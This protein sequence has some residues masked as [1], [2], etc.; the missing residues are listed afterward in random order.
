M[1]LLVARR[2]R[3]DVVPG[4]APAPAAGVGGGASS[5]GG[6]LGRRRHARERRA[7]RHDDVGAE[8]EVARARR[9]ASVEALVS[10]SERRNRSA[11][12]AARARACSRRRSR[13]GSPSAACRPRRCAASRPSGAR[14]SRSS[15]DALHARAVD[16]HDAAAWPAGSPSARSSSSPVFLAPPDE[17]AAEAARDRLR[18]RGIGILELGHGRR[19]SPRARPSRP[20]RRR[21]SACRR[22]A[23]PAPSCRA[24]SRRAA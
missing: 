17:R 23:A 19:G 5:F 18:D 4:G 1:R 11:E 9:A 13:R 22:R 3:P 10:P 21:S 15:A 2:S 16:R 14:P 8:P 6:L 7:D 12:S 24:G 20:M